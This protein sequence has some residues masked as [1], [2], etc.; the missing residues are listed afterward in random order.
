[1]KKPEPGDLI[2]AE[3]MKN[4]V[5]RIEVL[6][7]AQNPGTQPVPTLY[8]KVTENT[9][10]I[11]EGH[12]WFYDWESTRLELRGLNPEIIQSGIELVVQTPLARLELYRGFPKPAFF[13][14]QRYPIKLINDD[15]VSGGEID[16]NSSWP[17]LH[18][19]YQYN[20]PTFYDSIVFKLVAHGPFQP[21]DDPRLGKVFTPSG[22]G[23]RTARFE[24]TW[25]VKHFKRYW[26]VT[27]AIGWDQL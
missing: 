16:K 12:E 14:E 7:E 9:I 6:E 15:L 25:S 18:P 11:F 24:L 27:E 3:F 17:S 20:D 22:I 19:L 21:P 5:Q 23:P 1:M 13:I 8:G 10:Q 26:Y 4:L 2:T